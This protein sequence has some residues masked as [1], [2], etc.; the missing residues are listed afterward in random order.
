M[1]LHLPSMTTECF[2]TGN[3]FVEDE[4]VVSRLLRREEDGEVVRIDVQ[5]AAEED[6]ELPAGRIACRWV[7]AFKPKVVEENPEKELKLTAENLFLTLADPQNELSE[8]DGRLV[9]FLALMLERKR[10]IRP[11]GRNA[12]GTKDVYIHRGSKGLYEVPVGELTPEF[13]I[14]VQD[15]LSILVGAPES[16]EAAAAPEGETGADAP[17]AADGKP[18]EVTS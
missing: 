16:D 11:R 13:F 15:Q 7:Q 8:E 6:L 18:A 3:A 17:A 2:V 5:A 14:A 4:R 10:L 9:Q 12:D 1:D